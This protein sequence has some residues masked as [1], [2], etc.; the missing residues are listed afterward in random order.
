MDD[1]VHMELIS[2]NV[3]DFPEL[4][5]ILLQIEKLSDDL[6]NLRTFAESIKTATVNSI[7]NITGHDTD[8]SDNK[9]DI[10]NNA[11]EIGV[12]TSY[13]GLKG[14]FGDSTIE[15]EHKYSTGKKIHKLMLI[16]NVKVDKEGTIKRYAK[17]VDLTEVK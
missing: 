11:K 3:D 5:I 7:D 12:K 14:E 16:V 13:T 10:A 15:F 8:I 6:N 1:P 2:E 4:A 9:T 17:T